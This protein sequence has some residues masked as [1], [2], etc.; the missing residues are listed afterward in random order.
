MQFRSSGRK[1]AGIDDDTGKSDEGGKCV[2]LPSALYASQ[3]HT[4]RS[5]NG[6]KLAPDRTV[7]CISGTVWALV[8]APPSAFVG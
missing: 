3:G 8:E 4:V 2:C 6:T 7:T 1:L 5:R